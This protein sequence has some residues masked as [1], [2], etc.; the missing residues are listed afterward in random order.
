MTSVN[1]LKRGSIFRKGVDRLMIIPKKVKGAILP[2]TPKSLLPEALLEPAPSPQPIMGREEEEAKKKVRQRAR[3]SGR[4]QNILAGR[5]TSRRND[6]LK[7]ML[8]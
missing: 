4:E 5:L 8:G 1:P 7:T 2:K 3:R 6:I